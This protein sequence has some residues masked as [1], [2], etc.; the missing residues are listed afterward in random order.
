LVVTST[1]PSAATT[2]GADHAV[3]EHPAQHPVEHPY[4]YAYAPPG[5]IGGFFQRLGQRMPMWLA[6]A[7]VAVCGAAGVAYTLLA[8]P[9]NIDADARP[10]CVMKLLTGMDCPGCGG[11]RA[12]WYLLHGNIAAAARHHAPLVFAT[13]FVLYMYV[14]WTL[15]IVVKRKLLPQLRLPNTVLAGFLGA[16]IVFSVVRNL[17]WAPFTWLYV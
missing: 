17:P 5:R 11:T 3:A 12:A 15:G 8:D 4:A 16:W 14:A 9:T 6:P 7:G 10:T 13:P 2:E 1:V